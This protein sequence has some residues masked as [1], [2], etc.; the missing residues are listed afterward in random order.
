MSVEHKPSVDPVWTERIVRTLYAVCAAFVLVDLVAFATGWP[1]HKHG[2]YGFEQIP[3]FHAAYGFV[4][5]V[6]LVLLAKELR[7]LLMRPEDY[8]DA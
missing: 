4:S 8:Y 3:G 6:T 7:V 2:H 1:F 5:C